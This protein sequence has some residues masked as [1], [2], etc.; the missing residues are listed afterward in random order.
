MVDKKGFYEDYHFWKVLSHDSAATSSNFKTYSFM[1]DLVVGK[2][3]LEVG[4]GVGDFALFCSAKCVSSYTGI[5]FSRH[6]VTQCR[7]LVPEF[8]FIEGD[9]FKVLPD[10]ES[11]DVIFLAHCFEHFSKR[12]GVRLLKL[13]KK[14]LNVGGKIVLLMPNANA[15]FNAA[16]SRYIDVTH[17]VLYNEYSIKQIGFKA[18][19]SDVSSFNT[20]VGGNL[21]ERLLN[22]VVLFFFELFLRAAGYEKKNPRTA[23]FYTVLAVDDRYD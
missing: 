9:V 13:L 17:E 21:I 19:L 20:V 22:R 1:S 16:A 18:G 14:R 2:S 23:S 15:Y 11:Y 8:S 4:C 12:D 5:D 7:Y 3:V 6:N 10:Y